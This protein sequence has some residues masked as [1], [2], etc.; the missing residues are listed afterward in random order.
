VDVNVTIVGANV[1]E[2]GS[3]TGFVIDKSVLRSGKNVI[4]II[5]A[6]LLK[7]NR[8]DNVN[9]RPGLFQIITPAQTWK[10]KLFNGLAQVIVQST[11]EPGTIILSAVSGSLK[12]ELTIQSAVA[13]QRPAVTGN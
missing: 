2:T 5:A 4:A 3:N 8:W 13:E 10:R 9:T 6:P 7:K 1:K 11:G 12:K